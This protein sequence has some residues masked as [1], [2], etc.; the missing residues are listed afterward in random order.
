MRY[1]S[2]HL[3]FLRDGF[4]TMTVAEL[5]AAF[6]A[7]YGSSQARSAIGS[8]IKRKGITRGRRILLGKRLTF[9]REQ[10]DFIREEYRRLPLKDLAEE[11][12][13]RF[14]TGKTAGQIK[15]YVKNRGITSG[16][17][18]CFE[19]GLQSWNKGVKGY[20]GAN[21]TSFKKGHRPK[22]WT[23]LGTER[24]NRDR[25]IEIKVAE[26]DPHTGFPTRYRAKH[27]VIWERVNGPVPEGKI[28]IFLDGRKTN[29]VIENLACI[30]R[31]ELARLNQFGYTGL[32]SDLKP[33]MMALVQLK[34]K[35]HEL[36]R[37][38]RQ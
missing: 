7:R 9:T 26:R 10:T 3:A 20:M 1:T 36:L 31:S 2:E 24:I 29:C 6:N 13:A 15:S 30:S 34:V 33:S 16:R 14:G 21:V 17:T 11:F 32:P 35:A 18:G 22:N 38:C 27:V 23:P 8:T 19:K 37:G 28:V 12:S 5:T 4:Q 25:Y